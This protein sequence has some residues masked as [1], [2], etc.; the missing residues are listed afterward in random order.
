MKSYPPVELGPGVPKPPPGGGKNTPQGPRGR[1]PSKN[2]LSRGARPGARGPDNPPKKKSKPQNPFPR[3]QG[4]GFKN[5][6]KRGKR[7]W[8]P[9]GGVFPKQGA[10]QEPSRGAPNLTGK[11][12]PPFLFKKRN[13]I[14][15]SPN[16]FPG[17]VGEWAPGPLGKRGESGFPLLPSLYLGWWKPPRPHGG[18]IRKGGNLNPEGNPMG[19]REPLLWE[20]GG[21][22]P[23]GG[24]VAPGFWKTISSPF[25]RGPKNPPGF[26]GG[27]GK[28]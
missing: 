16:N 8:A 7:E 19:P 20:K 9:R 26:W 23:P 5:F 27:G 24:M 12:T 22:P 6:P 13:P 1:A 18:S 4:G 11:K 17:G 15:G 28:I 14:L 2:R 3:P 25:K 21:F 10:A